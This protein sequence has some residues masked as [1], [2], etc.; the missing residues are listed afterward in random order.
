MPVCP[1]WT[2]TEMGEW[3]GRTVED[4]AAG[5]VWAAPWTHPAF[6]GSFRTGRLSRGEDPNALALAVRFPESSPRLS[7]GNPACHGQR[8]RLKFQLRIGPGINPSSSPTQNVQ[9]NQKRRAK[10]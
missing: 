1:G 6:E 10:A 8:S 7:P 4:G 3:G 5:V 2:Q 9:A